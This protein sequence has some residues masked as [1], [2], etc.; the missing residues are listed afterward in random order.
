MSKNPIYYMKL[1]LQNISHR[2]YKLWLKRPT[3]YVKR[4][5]HIVTLWVVC[6]I[7]AMMILLISPAPAICI[8][9][10]NMFT[11]WTYINE[12]YRIY[13]YM[14]KYIYICIYIY[15]YMY[16]YVYVYIC[17]CIYVYICIYL[18]MYAYRHEYMHIYIYCTYTY[19]YMYTYTY[20]YIYISM[21]IYINIYICKYIYVGIEREI[22]IYKYIQIHISYNCESCV[23]M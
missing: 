21:Y 10:V 19:M 17:I 18:C 9:V 20:I 3:K 12:I 23:Y 15:M 4:D 5:Q 14:C 13:K 1:D 7:V 2:T 22:G 11:S 6:V 8:H 16:I